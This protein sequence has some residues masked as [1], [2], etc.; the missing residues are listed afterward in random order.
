MNDNNQN[1]RGIFFNQPINNEMNN[2]NPEPVSSPTPESTPVPEPTPTTEPNPVPTPEPAPDPFGSLSTGPAAEPSVF[3]NPTPIVSPEPQYTPP[4]TT[5]P[6]VSA[7]SE[8]KKIPTLAIIICV[9]VIVVGVLVGVFLVKGKSLFYK[10]TLTCTR[11]VEVSGKKRSDIKNV[12]YFKK[13]AIAIDMSSKY[14]LDYYTSEQAEEFD[15]EIKDEVEKLKEEAKEDGCK[16]NYKYKKGELFEYKISCGTD[17]MS[18][19]MGDEYKSKSAQELYD[20]VKKNY[21]DLLY[22]CK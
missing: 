1:N 21:T 2:S 7:P 14:Y 22:T 11:T 16:F 5:A 9:A 6:P 4:V 8:K 12:F 20:I 10:K 3:M 13:G 17:F 18:K 19:Q 15:K